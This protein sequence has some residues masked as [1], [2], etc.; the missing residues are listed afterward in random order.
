MARIKIK[1][2]P[3]GF[4]V[5]NGKL[6]K[7]VSYGGGFVTGDQVNYGLVTTY[8]NN[9]ESTA[10]Q[11]VRY[12]LSSVP[13]EFANIEAEGGETVLTDINNNG[14]FGLY[15]IKGPRHSQGGVPM[16]LPDQ[17]FVFSDTP[18][19]KMSKEDI[20]YLKFINFNKN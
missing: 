2:V 15:D 19:M 8:D 20:A 6:L 4:E 10:K 16:Y 1:K 3:H 17:S 18:K 9:G 14:T 7:K 11:D 5:T 12:S 13:R